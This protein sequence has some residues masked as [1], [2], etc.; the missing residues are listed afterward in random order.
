MSSPWSMDAVES[1]LRKIQVA[2]PAKE[3]DTPKANQKV[4]PPAFIL[5]KIGIQMTP[6]GVSGGHLPTGCT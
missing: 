4:E 3:R 1:A 2:A 5:F 6:P